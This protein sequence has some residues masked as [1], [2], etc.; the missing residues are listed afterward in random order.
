MAVLYRCTT[1]SYSKKYVSFLHATKHRVSYYMN[2]KLRYNL[3]CYLGKC[4]F[5]IF[6]ILLLLTK[7]VVKTTS[8]T[9]LQDINPQHY[10]QVFFSIIALS[11]ALILNTQ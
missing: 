10:K 11:T 9:Y 6:G 1:T 2:S 7:L 3:Q 4:S 5:W 8:N